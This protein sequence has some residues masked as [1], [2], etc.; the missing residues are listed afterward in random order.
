MQTTAA[1][2]IATGMAP[3]AVELED[4]D[5]VVRRYW[6]R[7][8]RFA[9]ASVRDYDAAQT[10]AQDCFYKAHRNR[11]HFRGDCSVNTWLMQIAVNLVRD[12][13]RNRRLQFWKR[14]EALDLTARWTPDGR[15]T[16]EEAAAIQEKVRAVWQAA[17][18]LSDRQRT[19]FLLRF[20]DEMEI[21]EI[22][23]ATGMAEGTVKVHL[24]RALQAIRECLGGKQ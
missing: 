10:I 12:S 1:G 15:L 2:E 6:P 24:F 16:P 14:G 17:G 8:F 4:F 11:A 5:E 23:A 3:D 22:A 13:L 7:V 20:V 19:V 21:L 18:A 9:L